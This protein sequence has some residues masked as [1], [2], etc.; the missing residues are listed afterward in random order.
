MLIWSWTF[1]LEGLLNIVRIF[2]NFYRHSQNFSGY[3]WLSSTVIIITDIHWRY[4]QIWLQNFYILL[5]KK[6]CESIWNKEYDKTYC[7]ALFLLTFV[8]ILH[9]NIFNRILFIP[10]FCQIKYIKF[11]V[12]IFYIVNEYVL[13]ISNDNN[14]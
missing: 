1:S 11:T 14:S 9:Y 2:H 3:S 7:I 10:I 4:K 13:I 5:S 6:P 8:L 12:K